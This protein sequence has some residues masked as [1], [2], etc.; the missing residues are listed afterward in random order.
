M[1]FVLCV[2]LNIEGW[3][4]ICSSDMVYSQN[5][6]DC[7]MDGWLSFLKKQSSYGWSLLRLHWNFRKKIAKFLG[8]FAKLL[9]PQNWILKIN[10]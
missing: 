8:K 2:A 10:E 5:W 1:V 6:L 7:P 3:L 4:K 9:K